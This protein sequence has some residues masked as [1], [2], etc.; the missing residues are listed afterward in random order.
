MISRSLRNDYLLVTTVGR[1]RHLGERE[2][3]EGWA[4]L[5]LLVH[6]SRDKLPPGEEQKTRECV[7]I[8]VSRNFTRSG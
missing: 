2:R 6:R 1:L 3:A 7:M 8:C 5:L 4:V